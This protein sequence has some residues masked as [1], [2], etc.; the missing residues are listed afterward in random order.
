MLSAA[1]CISRPRGLATHRSYSRVVVV[2][3]KTDIVD[4]QH[5]VAA[6]LADQIEVGDS[7]YTSRGR[8]LDLL[9]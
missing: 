4:K 3:C 8:V 1:V 6:T 9:R 5:R 7:S 2:G